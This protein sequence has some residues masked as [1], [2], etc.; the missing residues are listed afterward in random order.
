MSEKDA[1][2]L[3]A[4]V[5]ARLKEHRKSP[6]GRQMMRDAG[7]RQILIGIGAVVLAIL[8]TVVS[9]MLAQMGI[10]RGMYLIFGGATFLGVVY[11]L[12]GLVNVLR[13]L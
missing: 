12:M 7:M 4:H 11:I 5:E 1:K 6:E 10:L 8:L 3:V 2:A 13:H 9:Y